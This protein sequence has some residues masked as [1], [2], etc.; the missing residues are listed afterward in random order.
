MSRATFKSERHAALDM[1]FPTTR[2]PANDVFRKADAQRFAPKPRNW[3]FIA[4]TPLFAATRPASFAVG[5]ACIV[6]PARSRLRPLAAEL[7][8][9]AAAGRPWQ[10]RAVLRRLGE[11]RCLRSDAGMKPHACPRDEWQGRGEC[12]EHIDPTPAE[13][14]GGWLLAIVMGLALAGALVQWALERTS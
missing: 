7:Y 4:T 8:V 6:G 5:W 3:D 2:T 10:L 9:L 1:R 11:R 14:F 12:P 13:R